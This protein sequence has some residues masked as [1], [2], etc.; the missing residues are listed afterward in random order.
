MVAPLE[1]DKAC[2]ERRRI[3]MTTPRKIRVFAM[4]DHLLLRKGIIERFRELRPDVTLMDLQLP[5]M[6]GIDA[7]MPFIRS[8]PQPA[9]WP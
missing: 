7:S 6:N 4:D 9:S 8:F 3:E 2:F 1:V 5:D